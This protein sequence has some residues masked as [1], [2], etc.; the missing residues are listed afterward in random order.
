M[1]AV[2][3][4]FVV[5]G[6]VS[7]LQAA[8]HQVLHL[9]FPARAARPLISLSF[10]VMSPL[11]ETVLSDEPSRA[12]GTSVSILVLRSNSP[13]DCNTCGH[14]P[15]PRPHSSSLSPDVFGLDDEAT[16]LVRRV[17]RRRVGDGHGGPIRAERRQD[18]VGRLHRQAERAVRRE[19]GLK[20]HE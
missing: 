17:L 8:P 18:A 3:L 13:L 2:L 9:F 20:Q 11:Y 10:Q 4:L 19:I 16:L 15:P 1:S 6:R 7:I 14:A 5:A 12:N